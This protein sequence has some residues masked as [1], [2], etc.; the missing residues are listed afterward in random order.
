MLFQKIYHSFNLHV[1]CQD[2]VSPK[3][4]H[5]LLLMGATS[6]YTIYELN[7]PANLD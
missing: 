6:V 7:N 5:S 2:V 4:K 3:T 1:F